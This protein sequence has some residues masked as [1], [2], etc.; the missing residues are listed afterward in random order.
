[1]HFD[2]WILDKKDSLPQKRTFLFSQNV[3]HTAR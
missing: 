1:M 3:P 2:V